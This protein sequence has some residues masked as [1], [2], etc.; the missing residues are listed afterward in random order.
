M[1]TLISV[2]KN[3]Y[4]PFLFALPLFLCV[5]W[6]QGIVMDAILYVTQYVHTI[7]PS[8]FLGD[9]AFDFGNQGS[10]GFFS[11]IFG[12]FLERFGVSTGSFI[13]TLL[14]QLAWIVAFVFFVK[15]LLRLSRQRL[16]T[17]PVVALLACAFSNGA[18]FSHITWFHYLSSYA[19]SRSLSI[20][21]GLGGMALLFNQRRY[22]SLLLILAG[23]AIHPLTAGWCLSFWIF[24]L[25]PK[26]KI[27]IAIFAIISPFSL[28]FRFG[29]F[30]T[31]P[32]DWLARPL[33]NLE[34]ERLSAYVFLFVFF[35]SQIKLSRIKQVQNISSS[36]CMLIA[37]CL[38][39][40]LWG[41]FG[42][43]ILLYQ[44]QPWRALWIPSLV[45]APLGIC[46]IKNSFRSYSKKRLVSTRDLGVVL[47]FFSFF[48]S[49]HLF[50]ILFAS[51]M[52]LML[53]ERPLSLKGFAVAY[54]VI[55]FGGY[56]AQQ[57]LTWSLQGFPSFL[58]ISI[59]QIYHVRD[60]F[61]VYQFVFTVV[62]IV[63]F[64]K[65]RYFLPA[66]LLFFSIIFARFMLLPALPLFMVIF[67]KAEKKQ[68]WG[69][70]SVI[71]LLVALDGAIDT[72]L[73]NQFLT[74][75]F[76]RGQ[77]KTCFMAA[78]LFAAIY[79]SKKFSYKAIT[80][81]LLMCSIFALAGYGSHASSI[82]EKEKQLDSYLHRT[83]FPQIGERGRVLFFV[84]GDYPAN[85][86]LQFMTGS[87]FDK[88]AR[89]GSV[90]FKGHYRNSLE[91]S[92]LLYWR[93]RVPE[94]SVFFEYETI[95]AKIADADTLIDRVNF[96]CETREIH[97][98]VTDKGQ[99]P[100]A[101]EDSTMI[102]DSQKVYL[103][104]C[105]PDEK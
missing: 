85:P 41:D 99:L 14:M 55:I 10:L 84:S 40:N 31:Y 37:I 42:E 95:L 56:L 21:L 98:L 86:R 18:P 92:H 61:F 80:V 71:I 101:K 76:P 32:T 50:S 34:Y 94:S 104:A 82:L 28:L 45:A 1:P 81:C 26:T 8:R 74:Q 54:G 90:F 22:L 52:L 59:L 36:M 88:E 4:L 64:F 72:E 33:S 20:A 58:P 51:V 43:H 24:F 102:H 97:H 53:K 73:R 23:T 66:L 77:S 67:P 70:I 62:L 68:Y 29:V 30:D 16:W 91:R 100:F 65:K 38:Y 9:P 105:P 46:L 83:I 69:G 35:L 5:Y 48:V 60:S 75:C 11:P 63:L 25:F 13:Y 15:G 19:C 39:W 6:Y 103:Y 17:L 93:K 12:M 7:D 79:L 96:L 57:Y 89:V 78:F 2:L 3:K 47:L 27:P 87:Y 49:V 44:V